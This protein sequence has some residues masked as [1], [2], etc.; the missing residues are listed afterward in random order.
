MDKKLF[1]LKL[2]HTII[3]AFY[4]FIF[5]YILYAGIYNKIDL[6]LWIAIG[7][8]IIEVVILIIYKGKC[9]LT[10]LGYKYID[11]PEIG[12]DIFLPRWLAKYNQLIYGSGLI[13][14]ILII[15][16]RMTKIR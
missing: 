10:I 4:V 9:P 11:N 2:I 3:W 1:Y 7:F 16:Y 14:V 12:F 6:Y 13:I 8:E 15:I 5:C